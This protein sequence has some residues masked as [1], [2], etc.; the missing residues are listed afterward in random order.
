MLTALPQGNTLVRLGARIPPRHLQ[1]LR[2]IWGGR[3]Y[4]MRTACHQVSGG[5]GG[6]RGPGAQAQRVGGRLGRGLGRPRGRAGQ[7]LRQAAPEGGEW[8]DQEGSG[9]TQRQ[10]RPNTPIPAVFLVRAAREFDQHHFHLVEVLAAVGTR[11]HQ[12]APRCPRVITNTALPLTGAFAPLSVLLGSVAGAWHG[13]A[14]VCRDG[15]PGS[16][17]FRC[18]PSLG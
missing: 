4:L 8:R 12:G 1:L 13:E 17:G 6:S 11:V 7:G 9:Q 16:R 5:T 15:G 14:R 3:P 18:R 2:G 10:S